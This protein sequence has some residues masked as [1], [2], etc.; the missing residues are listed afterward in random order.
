[1]PFQAKNTLGNVPGGTLAAGITPFLQGP[2]GV[3]LVANAP[4][5][6]AVLSNAAHLAW[7]NC[8]DHRTTASC[9]ANLSNASLISEYAIAFL[10]RYL[11]NI[12][13]PILENPTLRS[14][15]TNSTSPPLRIPL[16]LDDRLPISDY[17]LL[18]LRLKSPDTS[19]KT[20]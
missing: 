2:K 4:V 15:N 11:E 6:F 10:N 17:R 14:R 20:H 7:L 16:F 1:M 9:L 3:F 13:E 5:Y 19:R 8:G 18:L 12:P